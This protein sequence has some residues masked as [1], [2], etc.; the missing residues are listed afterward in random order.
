MSLEASHFLSLSGLIDLVMAGV[1]MEGLALAWWHRRTG[2][3]LAPL[4]LACM[5][6]AGLFLMVA[7]RLSLAGA[8]PAWAWF[9]LAASGVLH[10]IDLRWR[11]R[12]ASAAWWHRAEG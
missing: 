7:L 11:Q 12:Q 2:A 9:G 5:L 3:G 6:G 10:A 1:L 4:E 8:H